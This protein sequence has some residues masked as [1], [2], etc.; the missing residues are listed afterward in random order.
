[1]TSREYIL[2][3]KRLQAYSEADFDLP[4]GFVSAAV[5]V[6]VTPITLTETSNLV[7][8]IGEPVRACIYEFFRRLV[9]STDEHYIESRDA[10]ERNEFIRLGLTDSILLQPMTD[11]DVLLTAELGLY[12]AAANQ[13]LNVINFHHNRRI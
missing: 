1:M 2:R 12:L 6:A 3:H 8:Q 5:K 9:R 10:A 7:R 13:G 4:T 11:W